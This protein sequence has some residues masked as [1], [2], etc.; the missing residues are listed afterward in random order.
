ME[1]HTTSSQ[2]KKSPGIPKIITTANR[3]YVQSDLFY[4]SCETNIKLDQEF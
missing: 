2:I 3:N 1:C 4:N